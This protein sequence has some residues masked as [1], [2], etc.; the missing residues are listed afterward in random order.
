MLR[1]WIDSGAVYP[2]TYAA[3]GAGLAVPHDR[4]LLEASADIL[5][6]RC[7]GCHQGDME[8]QGLLLRIT[9]GPAATTNCFPT[10]PVAVSHVI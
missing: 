2:G 4:T 10:I 8:C 3:E 6:R 9:S 7:A 1:L 5:K